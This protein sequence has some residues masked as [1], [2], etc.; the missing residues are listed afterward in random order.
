MAAGVGRVWLGH[1]GGVEVDME[2]LASYDGR[3]RCGEV[4][5]RCWDKTGESCRAQVR[6][7]TGRIGWG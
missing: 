5:V 2:I 7:W 3:G 6:R 1:G 4:M